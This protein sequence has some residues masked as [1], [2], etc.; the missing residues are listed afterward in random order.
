MFL[1]FA[2]E[3]LDSLKGLVADVMLDATGVVRCRLLAYSE[4]Y[5]EPCQ[6]LVAAVY[7]PAQISRESNG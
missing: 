2:H 1:L 6:N 4:G 5:E 7:V 3:I